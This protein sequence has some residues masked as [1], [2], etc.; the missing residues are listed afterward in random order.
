M[1]VLPLILLSLFCVGHTVFAFQ[2]T[3]LELTVTDESSAV[4]LNVT[5]R[6]IKNGAMVKEVKTSRSRKL[7]FSNIKPEQYVLEIEASGFKTFSEK[8]EVEI[9]NSFRTIKLEIAEIVENVEIDRSP[10]DKKIDPGNG[11]FTNFLARAE[12]EALP[13]DP[14][15]LKDALK[16]RFGEDAE[17]F[18]DGFSSGGLPRKSAIVSIKVNQSSFDAEYHKIGIAII[19]FT[20]KVRNDFSGDFNFNFNDAR[21]NAREPFSRIRY[22]EQEKSFDLY[23]TG[24]IRKD[25]TSFSIEASNTNTFNTATV[26]AI[27]PNGNFNNAI[28]SQSNQLQFGGKIRHNLSQFQTINLDYSHN[29]ND[30]T[31]LGIGG[32]DLPERAFD[33]HT[34][35][36]RIR[37]SQVGT[38]G[39]RFYNEFRF[40]YTNE[41]S[42]T[43]AVSDQRAAIVLGAF[44]IG[45]AGNDS[46][47][48]KQNISLGDNFLFGIKNHALKVGVLFEYERQRTISS[49]NQNGTFT[50][51]SLD[52]FLLNRP[53]T[54]SEK[55]GIR[56]V[57]FS[58]FQFSAFIQDDIRLRK[59]LL[60]SLGLRYELQSNLKDYNNFSPRIG[61]SWSPQESGKTTF[62]GG[63]ALFYNWF[64]TNNLATIL[65]QN[66]NQIPET[67]IINPGFPNP[68]AGG[69]SQ[70]L[71]RSFRKKASD[72]QNPYVFLAQFGIQRQLTEKASLRVQYSYQKVV[73]QFRSRDLNAP[74]NFVRPNSNFGRI[75][76]FESSAFFVNNTLRIDFT[77]TPTKTTYVSVNYRLAKSISDSNANFGLPSDSNNLRLDRSVSNIDQR[78]NVYATFGW[79]L[80]KGLRFSTIARANSP[81]PYT[82][83]TGIDNNGDT[84]FND[85]PIGIL[86]NSE[87]G[88]W[89]KQFDTSLSWQFSLEKKQENLPI[90]AN[91]NADFTKG[92]TIKLMISANNIFNQTNFTN[93]VGV[94]ASPFFRQPVSTDRPRR[95]EIGLRFSF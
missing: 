12:I 90:I 55:P 14:E 53:S 80:P 74:I 84:V 64:D 65:S 21:L 79:A 57:S 66:E 3:S 48:Q 9:G 34:R 82:I 35:G 72:L 85:R 30:S 17:F 27:L 50:F 18:V 78:H 44:T 93:F 68:F 42:R 95:I 29:R 92:K 8:I 69:T 41:T 86:R 19:E 83:T 81:L 22:P 1:K 25:K 2:V 59:G 15:L 45:G 94:Q 51:T 37:Y 71:P 46:N 23:L 24:P 61:F 76:Q 10:Q 39:E 11:A 73:H 60:L 13:D 28:R 49:E 54:F 47:T 4:I 52:N 31:N 20:T 56:N 16:Q 43:D 40:Q 36:N 26:T 88:T 32:F 91:P 89:K 70:I 87:R 75:L 63:V 7:V 6:L 67:V 62:R 77:T 5:A 33:L 58:R 38:V